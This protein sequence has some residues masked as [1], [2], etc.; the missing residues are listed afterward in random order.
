MIDGLQKKNQMMKKNFVHLSDM[1][2]REVDEEVKEEKGLKIVTPNKLLTRL[3]VL[4]AQISAENNSG[5]L[6]N[7]VSQIL[8][9]L[10]T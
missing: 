7:E 2:P 4:L 3:P 8:Y 9:L 10:S 1:P 5:K 6:I